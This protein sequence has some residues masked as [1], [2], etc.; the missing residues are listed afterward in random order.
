MHDVRI[1]DKESLYKIFK[2]ISWLDNCRWQAYQ[3]YNFINFS[4]NDL[5]NSEKILTHWICYIADRQMPFEI[6][7]DKGGYVFSEIVYKYSRNKLS[8]YDLLSEFYES[9]AEKGSTKYRFTSSDNIKFA[10]RYVTL[11][12][13]NILQTLEVLNSVA[14]Q[15]LVDFIVILLKKFFDEDDLLIRV[16]CG[17]HLLTYNLS[18]KKADPKKAIQI[19]DNTEFE[20]K[21]A[22]FK[23]T[24]TE[25]KKR[26]W[27]CI[28]DYKKGFYHKVFEEA[29]KESTGADSKALIHRWNSLAMD[30]IELPGDVWNNNPLF[31]D[32][33]ITPMIDFNGSK[34]LTMPKIVR[35]LYNQLKNN[36][37]INGFYPEQFDITFDFVP[38]MCSQKLCEVCVFGTKGIESICIPSTDKYCPV[39]L[40]SCNYM[41]K[42]SKDNC[43]IK[44]NI[45]RSICKTTR[46]QN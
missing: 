12:Y 4:R 26:L 37:N 22:A 46:S 10:S 33:L 40:V 23:K 38:R 14:N 19:L 16:A 21:L 20:K 17:L 41:V 35:N 34:S 9:H 13:Q 1:K 2:I 44:E 45:G 39:A 15:S 7:W 5:T 24:A 31:R 18:G 6:V 11:D 32:N 30:D 42:C 28:R 8:S 27:C 36:S 29:V 43:S 25:G 3:N